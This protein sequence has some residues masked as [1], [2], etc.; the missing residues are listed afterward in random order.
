MNPWHRIFLYEL[1]FTPHQYGDEI[2]LVLESKI[3]CAEIIQHTS[4]HLLPCASYVDAGIMNEI[5]K[6]KRVNFIN[7]SSTSIEELHYSCNLPIVLIDIIVGY[8]EDWNGEVPKMIL[9]QRQR[10][11]DAKFIETIN[12]IHAAPCFSLLPPPSQSSLDVIQ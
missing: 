12:A 4:P 3:Q 11:V 2:T 5:Q 7:T 10:K 8:I 9:S 1:R 6:R